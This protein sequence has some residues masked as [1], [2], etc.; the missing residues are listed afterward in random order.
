VAGGILRLGVPAAIKQI[1][2]SAPIWALTVIVAGLGTDALAAQ[3]I[4]FTAL[5]LSFLP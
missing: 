3:R 5:S 2:L 4:S 1:L